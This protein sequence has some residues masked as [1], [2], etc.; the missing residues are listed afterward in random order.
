MS[1]WQHRREPVEAVIECAGESD[2]ESYR[3]HICKEPPAIVF[4]QNVKDTPKSE[5]PDYDTLN[6]WQP[7]AVTLHSLKRWEAGEDHAQRFIL[8]SGWSLLDHAL[9]PWRDLSAP[10]YREAEA[11]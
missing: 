8:G 6:P 9:D 3:Q 10:R 1:R 4:C 5:R 7:G 11:A 2:R